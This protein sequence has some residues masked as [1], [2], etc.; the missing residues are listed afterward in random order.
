[1]ASPAPQY[2]LED[3]TAQLIASWLTQA[4]ELFILGHEYGHVICGHGT[5]KRM[6][7][8]EIANENV[9]E[10]RFSWEQEFEADS[11]GLMLAM[12]YYGRIGNFAIG[13]TGAEMFFSFSDI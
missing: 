3:R 6:I 12:E 11:V 1:M 13:Y 8:S 9:K 10:V 2:I 7:S 5:N 4:S